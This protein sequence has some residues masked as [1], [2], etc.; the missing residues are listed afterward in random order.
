MIP[1]LAS[2]YESGRLV[3]FIGAGMSRKKLAGWE[4]FVANLEKLAC[5]ASN[6]D[7][8]PK[9]RAQRS[10]ATIRNSTSEMQY[11]GKLGEALK[12]EEF[13]KAGAGWT[14]NNSDPID[15]L[16]QSILDFPIGSGEQR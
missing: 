1:L 5:S 8:H 9:I 16:Q 12:G 3:P 11:W 14:A 15:I 10:A 2:S 13:D 7:K 6:S 4:G